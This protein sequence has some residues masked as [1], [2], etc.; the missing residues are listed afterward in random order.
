MHNIEVSHVT[1]STMLENMCYSKQANRKMLQIGE[2][3][4]DRNAQ[5]EFIDKKAKKFI[6]IGEPVI[7]VDTK[8]KETIGNFKNPGQEYRQSNDT[9][10]ALDHDFPIKEL[11]KIAPYGV[12]LRLI[13]KLIM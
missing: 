5:F 1:I 9:R 7:S 4:P 12:L 6:K 11:G 8:K 2:P 3:H 13:N 10:K